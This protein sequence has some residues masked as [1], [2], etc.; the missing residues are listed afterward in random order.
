MSIE[1]IGFENLPNAYIKEVSL[2]DYNSNQIE[3]QVTV[4]VH[5]LKTGSIWFDT[6]ETL[7]QLLRIGLI[8]STNVD[9][10]NQLTRGEVSPVSMVSETRTIP[11][12]IE[13]ESNLIFEV[14]F[15]K[16]IP[17][18]TR[19][20]NLYSFCFVDKV[21]VLEEYGF[22]MSQDYYGPI[23]SE[24]VLN[25]SNIVANTSVFTQD[26]GQYWAGPVH[27]H[28]GRYMIGSYHTQTP[29]ANLGRLTIPNAKIKDF[30]GTKKTNN[31]T[32]DSSAGFFSDLIVSYSSDT[33]INA[34][35]MLNVKTLL[36][37]HTKYGSFLNRASS[38]VVSQILETFK[39]SLMTIQ[40][41]RIRV[42][43]QSTRLRSKKQVTQSIFSKKNIIKTYDIDGVIRNSTRLERNGSY[44]I[45]ESELRSDVGEPNRKRNE[46][47]KEQLS[48]YKK[49]AMIQELFFQ[50]GEE[51]RTFQF[52][53]YEL[54]EKTPGK[55]KYKIDMQ[56][57]DPVYAF[58]SNI[59]RSMKQDL[60]DIKRYASFAS[61]GRDLTIAG[62]NVQSLVNSYVSYYSYVYELTNREKDKLSLKMFALLNTQTAN[63]R[64]I[65]NF[66]KQYA[67]LYSEFLIFLDFNAEKTYSKKERV[68]IMS[69]NQTTSRIL[70]DKT[71]DKIIE[72]ASNAVGFAYMDRSKRSS[73]KIYSKFDI[74]NRA[75]E[76]TENN[77]L[78]TP[79]SNSPD[80]DTST[81]VGLSDIS[82]TKTTFFG[83]T[84]MNIGQ[85]R[86]LMGGTAY[87]PFD[88]LNTGLG[89]I[90]PQVSPFDNP[91]STGAPAIAVEGP[92]IPQQDA[93]DTGEA[94]V[95]SSKII[96][97][98]QSFVS[99]TDVIDSYNVVESKTGSSQK[100]N[101]AL[102]GYQNSRTYV[103]TIAATKL[104]S[105]DEA[106]NL[107]N[108]LKAV[109]AGQSPA[110]RTDYVTSGT[111]LL[112]NPK[113]KNY[114]ELNNFSVQQ[115]VYIDGFAQDNNNNILL[116]NPVYKS[117]LLNNFQLT[118]KPVI[119][120]LQSYTNNKFNITDENKVS[121]ID[122]SF[123]MSDI[124][125]TTKSE[126]QTIESAPNYN[127]LD[128]SYEFMNSNIVTQTNQ[129]MTVEIQQTT[130]A[131]QAPTTPQDT[132]N[133]PVSV[134]TNSFGSY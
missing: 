7:T 49:I 70:I 61:R 131:V 31:Q 110:T 54:T 83:P 130:G 44:D 40:R 71:F 100:V 72:P 5:D 8:I 91:P 119:C 17:I 109:I 128:I 120:F 27:Q 45:V 117:M 107:P 64:S 66:Q 133:V 114:Y 104:L 68:S 85:T 21:Q 3:I 106:T 24:R 74:E 36:K 59:S 134:N 22:S 73:M 96:G 26:N 115:L 103:T 93:E 129:P 37:K 2:F 76:E 95:D 98:G 58:L 51:I 75:N 46:I 97:S 88:P 42:Y 38:G 63:Q 108:Q 82:T 78:G 127:T 62:V 125:L 52:N 23:K 34:M 12:S 121:V 87:D 84:L 30:R 41:Q 92:K 10:S 11:A 6:S 16:S 102:A 55:Y 13:S 90:A 50:Y 4:R 112:A 32:T 48:D 94:F 99:Y 79:T 116:N 81:N 9:Q 113:T 57:S 111:D 118:S 33:D 69:K 53:D 47:F 65:K 14:T 80:L 101:N 29:H 105:G 35:F 56:F 25:N 1:F 89:A 132:V 19:H 20:L 18:N 123:I 124:N 60:S 15:R 77:F 122:S 28:N 86:L 67:D 126:S 39:I 43:N